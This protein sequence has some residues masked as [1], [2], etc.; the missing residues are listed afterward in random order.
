MH[1]IQMLVHV[2]DISHPNAIAQAQAVMQVLKELDIV[3]IPQ[4]MLWNKIDLVEDP[5]QIRAIA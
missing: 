4:L 5:D 2:V 1:S 3:H